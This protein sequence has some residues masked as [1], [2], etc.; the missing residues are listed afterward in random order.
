MQL[1]CGFKYILEFG[2][3][4]ETTCRATLSS[5]FFHSEFRSRSPIL[6][7][8]LFAKQHKLY[9]IFTHKEDA[10]FVVFAFPADLEVIEIVHEAVLDCNA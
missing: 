3:L 7:F 8:P 2:T 6:A 1:A 5:S 4:V 10:L 9:P